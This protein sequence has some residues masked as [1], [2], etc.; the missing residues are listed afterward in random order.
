MKYLSTFESYVDIDKKE[1]EVYRGADHKEGDYGNYFSMSKDFSEDYGDVIYQAT[2]KPNKIF[3]TLDERN[4]K[5]IFEAAGGEIYSP[6]YDKTYYDL[7]EFLDTS[8]SSDTWDI[9]EHYTH[10]IPSDYDCL[11]ITEGGV[12][13]FLVLDRSIL[14]DLKILE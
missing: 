14:H 7:N 3:D 13:N 6:Y 9:I 1:F 11:L 12:V 4:W 2:L 5:I 8:W 10:L